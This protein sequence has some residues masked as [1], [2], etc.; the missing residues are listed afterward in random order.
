LFLKYYNIRSCE[1]GLYF[2]NGEFKGL[3]DPGRQWILDLLNVVQVCIVSRRDVWLVHD[4]LDMIVRSGALA[5]RA[6]VLDLKDHQRALVWIDDRFDRILRPGL[7][8]YWTGP[9][10]VRV[11]VVD[12][13]QTRFEHAHLQHIVQSPKASL[14]LEVCRIARNSVG[15]LFLDGQYI[16]TVPP[17]MYAFWRNAAESRLVEVDR[18]EETAA[19]RSQ[20][21]TARLLENSPVLM[22][23]RELEVLE[24]IAG[25]SDLHVV[26]G[27]KGLAD[28]VVNLL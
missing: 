2:R 15:V 13:R 23:L 9:R 10:E 24:K 1:I 21:N 22:R 6:E 16:D 8:A 19:I 3:L 12:A 7:Y 14:A 26:L 5:G 28:R 20:A 25:N 11:E 4:R 17:G 18:R 27:E